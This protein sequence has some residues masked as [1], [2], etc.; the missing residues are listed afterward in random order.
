MAFTAYGLKDGAGNGFLGQIFT[1]ILAVL[2]IWTGLAIEMKRWH[3]RGKSGLWV[4]LPLVPIAG[5]IWAFIELGVCVGTLGPNAYGPAP[6]GMS[7]GA[8][9]EFASV[10]S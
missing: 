9:E 1:L 7:G 3:D 5:P 4:L 10:F 6:M 2:V 8:Y